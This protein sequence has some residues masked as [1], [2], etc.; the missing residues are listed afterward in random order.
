M[1]GGGK[2]VE[3]GE[4]VRKRYIFRDSDRFRQT[5]RPGQGDRE[6]ERSLTNFADRERYLKRKKESDEAEI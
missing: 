5:K 1:G 6:T 2:G 3:E 4:A